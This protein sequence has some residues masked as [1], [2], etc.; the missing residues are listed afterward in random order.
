MNKQ[1][2]LSKIQSAQNIAILGHIRPDGDCVGSCIGA[3]NYI[4]DNYNDKNVVVYLEEIPHKFRFLNG[5]GQIR[6]T[7]DTSV[8]QLAISLDCGARDRHGI[9][10][11]IF[12]NA[13]DTIC[14]DHHRSNEGFGD[15]FCCDPNASST[16]EILYRHL[17][18]D[19]ISKACAEA[20]YLGIVHDT[21]VFKYP[22][23][24][25]ET[26]K[27]AGEMIS[28]GV[29]SQYII[30]ETFYKVTYN[31]NKL[32]GEALMNAVLH[33]DGKVVSTCITMEMFKKYSTTK[34]DTDGIVD[35]LRVTDGVEVAIF[36]YQLTDH[37][38]KF[39]LRSIEAVDVSKI[40][41]SFGGGGHMRAAGFEAEGNVD[42]ILERIIGMV[43]E[44]L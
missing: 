34:E 33:L 14:I 24:S 22:S 8:Y 1:L 30:D 27:I 42:D 39:S 18:S 9:F 5:A 25:P 35:K 43:K 16:C 23:T 19:C 32:T 29:S 41:V 21:G 17:N 40:S 31:Q 3:Y 2:F 28:K 4:L 26:M 7:V 12:G 15:Y 20:L 38:Y 44:Q 36:I 11:E 6:N 10:S 37:V 13:E